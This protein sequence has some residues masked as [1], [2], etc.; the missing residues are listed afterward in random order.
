MPRSRRL[1]VL[2]ALAFAV[3]PVRAHDW[4]PANC[5]D[6]RDCYM[7]GEGQREPK[8]QY[9]PAGWRLHDGKLVALTDARISPDGHF[10]VCRIGGKPTNPIVHPAGEKPCFYAPQDAF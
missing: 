8:P 9:T 6:N 10:H 4:Y 5:C 2:L 3:L 7:M 1:V